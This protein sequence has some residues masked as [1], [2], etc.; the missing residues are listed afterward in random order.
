MSAVPPSLRRTWRPRL[1]VLLLALLAA[2]PAVHVVLRSEPARRNLV[3]WDEFDTALAML[4]RLHD[5]PSAGGVLRE[6]FAIN[7]EHRMVTSRALFAAGYAL[8]G[9]VN[10]DV[11]NLA[12]NA[13]LLGLVVLLVVHAGRGPREPVPPGVPGTPGQPGAPPEPWSGAGA[14]GKGTSGKTSSAVSVPAATAPCRPAPADAAGVAGTARAAAA[15]AGGVDAAG[16]SAGLF[17]AGSPMPRRLTLGLILA[18]LLFQF[19]HYENFLWSGSSIDHF[20]VVLLAAAALVSVARGTRAGLFVGAGFATLATFT[21]A[22]G[23]ATWIAGALLLRAVGDRRGAALW[24][25]LAA[26]AAAAFLYGFQLNRSQGFVSASPAGA[27]LVL[28]YWL[29]LL[30]MVPALGSKALAPWL[31]LGLLAAV[32]WLF[33]TG[34]FR[35]EPAF[36]ALLLFALGSLALIAVG[37]AQL[38][39]ETV[40]SRYLVLGATAW[41]LTLF[42]AAVRLAPAARPQRPLALLLLPLAAFNV[43]ANRAAAADTASWIECRDRAAAS[44]LRHGEDGRGPLHLHPAPAHATALLR[45]AEA[46]GVYRFPPLCREVPFPRVAQPST[47]LAYFVDQ[48]AVTGDSVYASGWAALPGTTAV[49]GRLHLLLRSPATGGI[50]LFTTVTESR[51]DVAKATGEPGWTQAGFQFV[52][53]RSELPAG[54]YQLGFLIEGPAGPEYVLTAHRVDLTA[55]GR[56]LLATGE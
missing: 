44:Y 30:G 46:A 55:E 3:Y 8:T 31:G 56:A 47:R 35:R 21:L 48:L 7:N 23:I 16:S 34:A 42:L 40:F 32:A 6:L 17:P 25:G 1:V 22:H 50:R 9:T 54:E 12:G 19:Q 5:R 29:T 51:P 10:F 27:G 4:L 45:R 20:Q 49:P 24:L 37:R 36:F 13:T 39:G 14:E 38:A 2:A 41:A 26:L 33:R 15:E 11:L 28:R 18:A 52:R 53:R 43:A